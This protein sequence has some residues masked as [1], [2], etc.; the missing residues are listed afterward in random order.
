MRCGLSFRLI[1][2]FVFEFEADLLVKLVWSVVFPCIFCWS[3]SS[4]C[5]GCELQRTWG[6]EVNADRCDTCDFPLKVS[7]FFLILSHFSCARVWALLVCSG[8][9]GFPWSDLHRWIQHSLS[10]SVT[11]SWIFFTM[12]F[13]FWSAF[14]FSSSNIFFNGLLMYPNHPHLVF[15]LDGVAGGL[16]H[17]LMAFC[18]ITFVASFSASLSDLV[19]FR[20]VSIIWFLVMWRM[21]W[22]LVQFVRCSVSKIDFSRGYDHPRGWGYPDSWLNARP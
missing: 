22:V 10:S 14:H 13:Q 9:T 21:L 7:A 2:S 15:H 8:S 5:C 3:S 19:S 11:T 20:I 16:N 18:T 1:V 6:D 17:S 12:L 4:V